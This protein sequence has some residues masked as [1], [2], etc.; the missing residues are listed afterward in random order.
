MKN[1]KKLT[2]IIAIGL[3]LG[4]YNSFAQTVEELLPKAIQLEEVKGDLDNAIKTYQLI[5]NK[6]PDNREVCAEAML[7][8]GMCYEKLGLDQA[9]QTFRDVISK[10]SEQADKVAMARDRISRLDAYSSELIAKAEQHF[11]SG[12]ELFKKWDYESAIKEYENAVRSGPNTQLALNAQYCIGQSWYRAGK[13]DAALAT[14]TKLIEENPKSSI[15]PVTELMVAQVQNAMAND[16]NRVINN[17]QNENTVVDPKTGITYKKIKTF[18][19]KN[20]LITY[21]TGGFNLSPDCRFITSDNKIIPV[22]GSDAFDLVTMNSARTVYA[23]D[24]KKAAFYADSAIWIVPVSPETGKSSGKPVKLVEGYYR[25]LPIVSWSPDSK[26][27][28]FAR[29]D[30]TVTGDIW[31]CE[32]E[33]GNLMPVTNSSEME[34]GPSWSQDGRSIAYL[35][36]GKERNVWLASQDGKET[37]MI[38]RN[39]GVPFFWSKDSKWMFHTGNGNNHLYSPDQDKNIKVE[40]PKEVGVFAA[41]SPDGKKMFFYQPSYDLKWKTEVVS[42]LGGLPFTPEFAQPSYDSRWSNDNRTIL[43]NS[44]NDHGD[45]T[46]EIIR[47]GGGDPV[48][49]TINVEMNVKPYSIGTSPDLTKLLFTT[50][51]EDRKRDIFVAPFSLTEA[52]TTGP[53]RRIFE[54]WSGGVM[55]GSISWSQDATKVAVIHEGDI[56]ICTLQDGNLKKLTDTPVPEQGIAF[57][58]N[59]KMISYFIPD[60]LTSTLCIIPS[61]GG[62]TKMIYNK[63]DAAT[64]SYDSKSLAIISENE[65]EIISP[66]GKLMRQLVNIKELGIDE[67]DL[68]GFSRDDK[69]LALIGYFSNN[70]KAFI[71]VYSMETGKITRLGEENINDNKYSL[72]WSPDGKMLSYQTYEILKVR[73]EGSLWEANFEE[74]LKKLEE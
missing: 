52:T 58:P 8:L 49:V 37:R 70:E 33:N 26:K 40:P 67:V 11:K 10:Y 60:N 30:K 61:N 42:S 19:G 62:D 43:V 46:I 27:F 47:L 64:W 29:F 4:S 2:T 51:R 18:T 72:S 7:H 12:N 68:S 66:D 38:V 74:V 28:A 31:T 17:P 36:M 3:V 63:C 55:S 44:E 73:P 59:G 35:S 71:I 24:M 14:F 23:P 69:N 1:G 5:L 57:S 41:F 32:L 16:K 34:F 21:T 13:Y 54:G 25:F 39:G 56:W 53:A 65:L 20:D 48:K 22:D 45:R 9:R 50:L 6:F 15:S